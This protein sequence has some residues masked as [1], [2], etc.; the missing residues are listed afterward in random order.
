M[1]LPL[2]L[3]VVSFWSQVPSNSRQYMPSIAG[4]YAAAVTPPELKEGYLI[5]HKVI[6][7]Y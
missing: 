4:L 2:P 7:N 1:I 3:R 6:E 5:I